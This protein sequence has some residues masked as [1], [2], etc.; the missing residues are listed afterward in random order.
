MIKIDKLTEK[1]F[2]K[3]EDL[4]AKGENDEAIKI[5]KE[6]EKQYPELPPVLNS[7]ALIYTS[8]KNFN[9]AEIYFKKCMK[10]EPVPLVCINNF[11]K[12][13]HNHDYFLKALPLLQ[14]SLSQNI[15]QIEIVEITARCLFE[16]DLKKEANNFY[17]EMLKKFQDNKMIKTLYGKNLLRMNKHSEALG[18]IKETS[19]DIEFGEK[20]YKIN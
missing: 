11:A 7:I 2:L 12:L 6:I 19:G 18:I 4:R 13:Y 17:Q 8:L 15:Q 1:K 20:Q 14:K 3:A 5:F 10:I 16:A 9:E